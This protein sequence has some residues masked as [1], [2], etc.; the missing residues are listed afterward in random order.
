LENKNSKFQ[1]NQPSK[2]RKKS[3]TKTQDKNQTSMKVKAVMFVPY[4][5]HSELGTRLG[6]VKRRCRA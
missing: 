3:M 1:Y 2:K 4:T 5:A 6:I